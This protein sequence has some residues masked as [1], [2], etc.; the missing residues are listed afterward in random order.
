MVA[1]KIKQGIGV[2]RNHLVA[3]WA[4]PQGITVVH[5][6]VPDQGVPS[7]GRWCRVPV[8]AGVQEHAT[9]GFAGSG[10]TFRTTGVAL[11]QIYTPLGDG[12]GAAYALLDELAA[13]CRGVTLA[14]PPVVRF[15]PP[16]MSAQPVREGAFWQT[17][18]TA[19]FTI[20]ET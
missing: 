2:V 8:Y 3:N 15:Q 20:E 4:T 6:N 16:Y 18:L 10:A 17:V 12:D 1:S 5:D 11:L 13:A 14:G 19:D 7:V 9:L